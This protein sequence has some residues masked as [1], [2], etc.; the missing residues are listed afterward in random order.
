[1][2]VNQRKKALNMSENTEIRIGLVG[3]GNVALHQLAALSR[4][5]AFNIVG[6]LDVNPQKQEQVKNLPF[7]TDLED[8]LN[9][10]K[11][12]VVMV[13]T[14]VD[15]HFEVARTILESGQGVLLE[16]PATSNM[17]EFNRL[18][19]ISRQKD[20]PLAIAFH[21]AFAKDLLWF[22]DSKGRF[23]EDF[24]P[25][26]GFRSNFYDPYI[27]NGVLLPQAHSLK[28]SWFDSGINAL[29]V[30]GQLV[31][32][33]SLEI[34][35]VMLTKLPQYDC[36]EIQGTTHFSFSPEGL[37]KEG[38]GSIDTNWALGLNYKATNLYF[39][40]S[41]NEIIL[42]HS[43]QQVFLVNEKGETTLLADCSGDYP[44]L[45]N[46]YMGVFRNLQSQLESG[47]DNLDYAAKLHSLLYSAAESNVRL[48]FP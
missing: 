16:K 46:H 1:M 29:S 44:R 42:H 25:L 37:L 30:I 27:E 34:R 26:T 7:F 22:L 18:V 19:E 32:I 24:G 21:A 14:P 35:D 3:I 4:L 28:G 40:H 39:G 36:S 11:A 9:S 48:L 23:L 47:E 10:V 33:D 12:D 45:V 20:V 31:N 2:N 13:S 15:S 43:R 6:A 17:D 38:R 8:F 5:P 41:G